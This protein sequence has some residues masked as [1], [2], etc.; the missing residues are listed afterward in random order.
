MLKERVCRRAQKKENKMKELIKR[1]TRYTHHRHLIEA[2]D[3]EDEPKTTSAAADGT[4]A[5][6][7]NK[8]PSPPPPSNP[9]DEAHYNAALAVTAA[10]ALGFAGGGPAGADAAGFITAIAT[11][12]QSQCHNVGN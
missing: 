4:S 8:L 1:T 9:I 12:G 3:G 11:C 2:Y 6:S 10:A 7:I 5:S